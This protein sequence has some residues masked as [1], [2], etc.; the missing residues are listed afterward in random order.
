MPTGYRSSMTMSAVAVALRLGHAGSEGKAIGAMYSVLAVAA[1]ARIAVVAGHLQ[2]V[3]A[4][5]LALPWL[6]AI[7]WLVAGFMLLPAARRPAHSP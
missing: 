4:I 3:S 2:H 7:A 1:V 5:A 6:P